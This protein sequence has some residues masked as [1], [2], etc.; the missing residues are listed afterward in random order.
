MSRKFLPMPILR[1]DG[2][3]WTNE[4]N[5]K[6]KAK[7]PN[8]DSGFFIDVVFLLFV[9]QFKGTFYMSTTFPLVMTWKDQNS[10]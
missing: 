8:E 7:I 9:Q 1:E 4:N 10:L 2:A 6:Y 5:L 3:Y